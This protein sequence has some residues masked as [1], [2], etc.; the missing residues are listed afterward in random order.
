M[1]YCRLNEE[2]LLDKSHLPVMMVINMVSED[3]FLSV[4]E[5]LSAGYGFGEEYGACTLPDDLDD[6]DRANGEKLH[7]AEFG[8][9]SGEEITIDFKT[10]YYYLK[11]LCERYIDSGP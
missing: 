3:R 5:G 6:F 4:L 11:I 10:L 7:G 9:H 8:L 2:D 1:K